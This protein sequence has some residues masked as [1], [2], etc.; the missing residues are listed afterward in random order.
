[1][2]VRRSSTRLHPGLRLGV[3]GSRWTTAAFV[4]VWVVLAWSGALKTSS[5]TSASTS[6]PASDR[7]QFIVKYEL[8]LGYS[9]EQTLEASRT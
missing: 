3:C 7:G 2:R 9:I 1:M 5:A 4:L 6:S 8:P